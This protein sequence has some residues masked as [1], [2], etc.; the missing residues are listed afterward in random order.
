[1]SAL[2]S[3]C[4]FCLPQGI[5][6]KGIASSHGITILRQ[7]QDARFCSHLQRDRIDRGKSGHALFEQSKCTWVAGNARL[8]NPRDANRNADAERLGLQVGVVAQKCADATAKFLLARKA[9]LVSATCTD[10]R[11]A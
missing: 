3:R 6:G 10:K 2:R 7:A 11:A 9:A 4:H 5:A 8:G 1:M